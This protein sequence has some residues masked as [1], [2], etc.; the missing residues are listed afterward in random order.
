MK[1]SLKR[2]PIALQ[3]TL[4][5]SLIV[6][7]MV[8]I[9]VTNY[10]RSVEVVKRDNS[11][12]LQG[13]ITQIKQ[14][15]A[16]NSMHIVRILDTV[17][18]NGQ[19]VQKYFYVTDQVEK[20][21]A[22]TQL[23]NY[24]SDMMGMKAGILD[25]ALVGRN[26]TK[27]NLAGD[28]NQLTPIAEEIPGNTLFYY[29]GYKEITMA[30]KTIPVM[31]VGA[32]IYST[33]DFNEGSNRIG[34]VLIAVDIKALFDSNFPDHLFKGA[35]LY[36]S[37]R[38]GHVFF[39]NDESAP[40]G[41][42][43]P[44]KIF[45]GTNRENLIQIDNIPDL[46]GAIAIEM[47]NR[48]LLRGINDIRKQQ[49]ILVAIALVLLIVP[50]LF[51]IN[52]ILQ[53][54]KKM[55]RLMN[56]VRL[57]RKSHLSKRIQVDGYAEMI[58]MA[59][60]F[61]EMMAEIEDLTERLVA[62]KRL[63]YET[64]L[65]KRRAELSY[66]QS[67]I[68]PHF[69][70]NTL[71]SIKGL[72]VDEG[73]TQI[74]ELTKALALFFRFSIKGPD[75]VTLERELTIIKNYIFIHQIR[76]GER[77]QVEYDFEPDCLSSTIPKMILQPIVENAIFHGIEPLQRNGRL[78]IKGYSD[79]INLYLSVQDNGTGISSERLEKINE[80]IDQRIAKDE[81]DDQ[82]EHSIGLINVLDRIRIKFGEEYGLQITSQL[83]GG[84]QVLLNMP[85][86]REASCIQSSLL[87]TRNS[88][89][90]A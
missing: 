55:M 59:T 23:K 29:A 57:G 71:E 45:A 77:L 87:M 79:G 25:I 18:Y 44:E 74:F 53:P 78:L 24:L 50:F 89:L 40:I 21:E 10:F 15:I 63:L 90:K 4:L 2:L 46:A 84:T 32:P 3:L 82:T 6:I 58:I 7:T 26:N 34:T 52:N 9:M 64:E 11:N 36:M 86:R 76:F 13:G 83:Q 39:T 12:Y 68:N 62:G 14:T 66:L 42:L 1:V 30:N 51:I 43:I 72:A 22:Y 33:T 81:Q 75:M 41:S 5:T 73:A 35:T 70:Y 20:F 16:A 17:A 65:V 56:E 85:L 49:L 37:D 80:S 67:Q 61:N 27:M 31:V 8:L 38:Y 48:I 19:T 54:L 88:S 47:P 28:V 69:L 60:R